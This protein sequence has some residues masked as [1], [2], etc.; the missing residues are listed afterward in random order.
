[1][2]RKPPDLTV[3]DSGIQTDG[4]K[5]L[6]PQRAPAGSRQEA[7]VQG[8]GALCSDVVCMVHCIAGAVKGSQCCGDSYCLTEH[9]FELEPLKD[10]I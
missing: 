9:L 5:S 8:R 7:L 10:E 2:L 3:C 6:C 1:M 4:K